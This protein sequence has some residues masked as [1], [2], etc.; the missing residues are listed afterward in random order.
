MSR[1]ADV[2]ALDPWLADCLLAACGCVFEVREDLATAAGRSPHLLCGD[3]DGQCS[4]RPQLVRY[5]TTDHLCST[6]SLSF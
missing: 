3:G 6:V 2:G 1:R 5:F 4:N